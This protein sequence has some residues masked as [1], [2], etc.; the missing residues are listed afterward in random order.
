MEEDH[1][2]ILGKPAIK[3]V[4]KCSGCGVTDKN[5]QRDVVYECPHCD[6]QNHLKYFNNVQNS[7]M[8]Y[9]HMIL[10]K[11]R[12]CNTII[13]QCI[14]DQQVYLDALL[15]QFNQWIEEESRTHEQEKKIKTHCLDCNEYYNWKENKT[16]PKCKS[17]KQKP[18][19]NLHY[20]KS[21]WTKKTI[22]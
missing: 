19:A 15:N 10:Q 22:I 16:C 2:I 6:T 9:T 13:V 8:F 21:T 11:L 3:I 5:I 18:P 14:P 17:K 20:I 4:H 12:Y 7:L 1:I